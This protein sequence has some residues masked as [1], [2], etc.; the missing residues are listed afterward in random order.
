MNSP[1]STSHRSSL[2]SSST[3][4]IFF[5]IAMKWIS[6]SR[7][8]SSGGICILSCI[9]YFLSFLANAGD[10]TG[11]NVP[12]SDPGKIILCSLVSL[13]IPISSGLVLHA[14]SASINRSVDLTSSVRGLPSKNEYVFSRATA[15]SLSTNKLASILDLGGS[16]ISFLLYTSIA[17]REIW[18]ALIVII[19]FLDST[20]PWNNLTLN[21]PIIF[22]VLFSK[23]ILAF[24]ASS[25]DAPISNMS[26]DSSV[27][28]E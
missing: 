26:H 3:S 12:S 18:V 6:S 21:A 4:S 5:K 19:Y 1:D 16:L 28:M 15:C 10:T 13:I 22:M 2:S 25:V 8:G 9:P 23:L 27:A 7:S 11:F 20:G 24:N 14:N 17:L